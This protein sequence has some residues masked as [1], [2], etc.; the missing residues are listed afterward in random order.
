MQT[1]QDARIMEGLKTKSAYIETVVKYKESSSYETRKSGAWKTRHGTP[2]DISKGGG[3]K[4]RRYTST[5]V[6]GA[7]S[8]IKYE[9]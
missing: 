6:T 4:F 3:N 5:Y 1:N 2:N 8:N 9:G 7:Y